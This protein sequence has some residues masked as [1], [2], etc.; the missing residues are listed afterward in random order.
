MD[1]IKAASEDFRYLLDRGYRRSTALNFVCGHY[2]LGKKQ[3]NIIVRSVYSEKEIKDHRKRLWPIEKIRGRRLVIDGFNVLIGAECALGRGPI[4]KAQDGLHRDSLGLSGRYKPGLFTEPAIEGILNILKKHGPK[5]VLFIFDSQVS[6]SGELAA[7]VRRK[8]DEMG[9]D[10]DARTAPN[11]D[12]EIKRLN[13]ITATSDT[14]IIEKVDR[15]VDL[16]GE[17]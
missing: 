6:R 1:K 10:G 13:W 5:K 4:I 14:A 15:V 17:I 2:R 11:V 12:Y 7:L 8:M 16:V 9:V 3:R